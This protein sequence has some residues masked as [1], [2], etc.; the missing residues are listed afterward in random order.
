MRI[1]PALVLSLLPSLLFAQGTAPNTQPPSVK[2][3]VLQFTLE[4]S[5]IFPGTTR[6]F[7]VYVPAAYRPEKPACLYVHQDGVANNAPEVFDQ[8]IAKGEMPVTIG[9]FVQPGRVKAF[10]PDTGDR[11]NRSFEYDSLSADY[12]KFLA[13]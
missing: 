7:W 9:V 11:V 13:L 5:K 8:L 3:E 6:Q 4:H 1:P 10:A 12:A 2:G